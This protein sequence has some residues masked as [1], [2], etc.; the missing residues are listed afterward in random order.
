M[1]AAVTS[2][3]VTSRVADWKDR[4][5]E[6]FARIELLA[7]KFPAISLSRDSIPT[8][9]EEMMKQYHVSPPALTKLV[10]KGPNGKIQIVPYGL[11]VIG[12]NGRL[13]VFVNDAASILVDA[14]EPGAKLPDWQL[15]DAHNRRKGVPFDDALVTKLVQS[16][17]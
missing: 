6:L 15:F 3:T 10:L 11:W 4:L 13:D 9:E 2:E 7:K 17:A 8:R 1:T 12:A 14:S 16:V 5:D